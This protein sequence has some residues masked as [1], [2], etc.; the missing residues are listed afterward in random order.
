M[1]ADAGVCV[2]R[3]PESEDWNSGSNARSE[4][5]FLV[6]LRETRRTMDEDKREILSRGVSD[7]AISSMVGTESNDRFEGVLGAGILALM[8]VGV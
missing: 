6:N 5:R 7:F 4:V 3:V 2:F 1:H 8:L